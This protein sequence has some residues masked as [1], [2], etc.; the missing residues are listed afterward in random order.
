MIVTRCVHVVRAALLI[1]I[2]ACSRTK[3]TPSTTQTA[4]GDVAPLVSSVAFPAFRLVIEPAGNE[5]RYRVREQLVGKDLPTDAVGVTQGVSGE[6]DFA[7]DGTVLPS[8]SKIMIDVSGLKSDQSRRDNYVRTRLLETEKFPAVIFEPTSVR[9]AP[10]VLPTTGETAFSLLGNLTVKGVTKPAI[11][12]IS[13]KFGP[14]AV[15]GTASTAFSFT[16][17]AIPQPKVPVLLSV[18]DTIK[19]EYDFSMAVKR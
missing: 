1:T 12:F 11:W 7:D 16:D 5:A 13:C 17:F 10:K 3:S 9:G 6:I 15:T 18:A 14:T 4:N 2:V 8:T 19:L